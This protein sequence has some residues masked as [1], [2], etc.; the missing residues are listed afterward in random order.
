MQLILF[1]SFTISLALAQNLPQDLPRGSFS[2]PNTG[3]KWRYW[4]E[5][6]D[7]D[8]DALR[9]DISEMAHVGSSGFELLW[10]N[11]GQQVI[12]DP[13]EVAFGSDRF[14]TVT[15][16]AVQAALAN[17]ITIDF[18]MGPSQGAGVPVFPE[19]VDKEGMNTELVFGSHFIEAGNSFDG[20]LPD[21]TIVPFVDFVGGTIEGANITS[22]KL[23]AVIGASLAPGSNT[24]AA[25]ISLDFNSLVDLTA[26]VQGSVE[27]DTA[28]ISWAPSSNGTSVLLTYFSRRNGYP[29]AKGGFNGPEPDKPGS[30][31]SFVVD[32]FSPKGANVTASFMQ[33]NLLS[34]EDIGAMLRQPGVGQYMWE[35][36]MEFVGQVFWTEAFP[37]RFVERHGYNVS[38]ALPVLHSLKPIMR[39]QEPNQ[40]FDYGDSINWSRFTEDYSDTLT[41]L[42]ADYMSALSSWSR[43]LGMSFSNQPAYNF[44]LDTAA[45]AAIPD[46]PEIE[47]LGVPTIDQAR[48]LSAGV[49]LGN[50]PIFSSETAARLGEAYAIRMIEV[51][52]DA[53]TQYAGGVN[54]VMLHGYAYSGNYPNTTWPGLTTFGFFFADM[55]GPRMPAWDHYREYL[56][57]LS[58]TQYVLQE[59]VAKVDLAIYRKDYNLSESQPFQGTSL[60]EAGYTYEYVSPE[61]LKLPGVSVIDGRLAPSGPAYKAFVLSRISNITLDAAQR[62]MEYADSG[63]PIVFVGSTPDDI[64]GYEVGDEQKSKVKDLMNE[65]VGKPGVKIV[66][67][68]EDVAGALKGVGVLPVA[69]A[70][71]A[72][73]NL[74]TVVRQVEDGDDDGCDSEQTAHFYLFNNNVS[75][76]GSTTGPINFTLTLNPGFKGTPFMLDAWTGEVSPVAAYTVDDDS[77]VITIPSVSLAPAQTILFTVTTASEFEGVAAPSSH[78]T[79]IDEGVVAVGL[80]DAVAELRSFEEGEKQISFDNGSTRTVS[81]SLD[82]EVPR[83]LDGWKLNI[84]AWTP[85]VD[86][87]LNDTTQG[88][89]VHLPP[90]D[91]STTGLVPWDQLEIEG[92]TMVNVSGVGTYVTSFEWDHAEDGGVGAQL[93]FGEVFHTV[94]AWL[95]GVRIPTADPTNPVVD[96]SALMKQGRNEL[97]VDTAST[98]LNIIN[99]VMVSLSVSR[100]FN[101]PAGPQHYGLIAPVTLIPYAR[102]NVLL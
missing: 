64:P 102:V 35:D 40:T 101:F 100:Q 77:G 83:E 66:D 80:S 98:L 90:V 54:V 46:T 73:P 32:H 72:S 22:K 88:L 33:S 49:H 25:R 93:D 99:A 61:N 68:E 58:R 71:P 74:Y 91:L 60:V 42:Y 19:D 85:P 38:L 8:L 9:S 45:S 43:S 50:H 56:D 12:V 5:D 70:N 39:S 29:E 86:I 97:R 31:G 51:L 4:I 21:P 6:A 84:T 36:S 92:E 15:A 30:W 28:S 27:D 81:F 96:V 1:L 57:F 87:S 7:V 89:F 59:G 14:V 18:T 47:S 24:S 44:H 37:E 65:L 69:S 10:Q 62:L 94:K 2:L 26:Q 17:N 79:G 34:R 52:E 78:L 13:T 48:Q 67:N 11:Y 82:G 20:P 23:V 16:A 76:S 55:H 3:V 75:T 53:K 41:T 63:L 95:N